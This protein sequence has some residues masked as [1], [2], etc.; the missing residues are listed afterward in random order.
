MAKPPSVPPPASPPPPPSSP[1]PPGLP[2]LASGTRIE[3]YLCARAAFSG[4]PLLVDEQA[5]LDAL[6]L[7]LR[8][9]QGRLATLPPG[10]V[11]QPWPTQPIERLW[12]HCDLLTLVI[13]VPQWPN[14]RDSLCAFTEQPDACKGDDSFSFA[15]PACGSMVL[16]LSHGFVGEEAVTFRA[17]IVDAI[18]ARA[19][20]LSPRNM[21]AIRGVYF[22]DVAPPC[23]GEA[24]PNPTESLVISLSSFAWALCLGWAA[25][26]WHRRRGLGGRVLTALESAALR[27]A[28]T[29]SNSS[30]LPIQTDPS[31]LRGGRQERG[32]A[33]RPPPIDL[34]TVAHRHCRCHWRWSRDG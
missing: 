25:R 18:V 31:H 30:I 7:E 9:W 16:T 11:P 3:G 29:P 23:T 22:L 21:S 27:C 20:G 32:S 8:L 13:G 19:D 17:P 28:P 12:Q 14:A 33:V 15:P 4:V 5:W 2:P 6:S 26:R 1:R 24:G 34:G 10:S